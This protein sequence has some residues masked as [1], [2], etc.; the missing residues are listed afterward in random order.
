[1]RKSSGNHSRGFA[2]GANEGSETEIKD[3]EEGNAMHEETTS[4]DLQDRVALIENMIAEGRRNTESWG[5]TFLLWGIAYYVAIAWAT[6]G[7][8]SSIFRG[9]ELAWPVTMIAACVLT[10]VIGFRKGK[11][12]PGTTVGRAIVS[13]WISLG[14]SMLVLFPS[15]AISGRLD[16]H[17]F[18]ALVAAMLGAANGASGL[19]LRW[20]A[21][22]VCGIVWWV[23]SAASCFGSNAQVMAVFL[24]A[25]FLCQI[26]FGTYA[27]ILESRR[28]ARHGVVHA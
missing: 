24:A 21:Q 2:A 27:M 18:V 11:G 3:A 8:S 1:L 9:S 23:T 28:R 17:G 7:Q 22:I 16:E 12:H 13:I 15:L 5:W 19:I 10:M 6:W 20:K 26:V 4:R 25:I 14:I